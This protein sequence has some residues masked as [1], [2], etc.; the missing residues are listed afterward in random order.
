[1]V[2]SV[3]Q[4]A[5]PPAIPQPPPLPPHV[6]AARDL[7]RGMSAVPAK[8]FQR[9]G[10]ARQ[11]EAVRAAVEA[12]TAIAIQRDIV[13]CGSADVLMMMDGGLD[14]TSCAQASG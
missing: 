13:R 2:V 5:P 3:M 8:P 11:S 4:P 9:L 1:M 12:V 7:L 10:A 14:R 6:R